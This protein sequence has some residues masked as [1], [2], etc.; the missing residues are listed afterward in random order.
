MAL[1]IVIN[2]ERGL[3][4]RPPTDLKRRMLG[5]IAG[6]CT[7]KL[8]ICQVRSCIPAHETLF[9]ERMEV[10]YILCRP[11]EIKL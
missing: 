3:N 7:S 6:T 4:K 8:C 11:Q 5:C 9:A 1:Y 2:N 10:R